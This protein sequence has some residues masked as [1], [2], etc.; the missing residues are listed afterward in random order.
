[1]LKEDAFYTGIYLGKN[2]EGNEFSATQLLVSVVKNIPWALKRRQW[3]GSE[4]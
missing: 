4:K 1:M 2:S 3:V